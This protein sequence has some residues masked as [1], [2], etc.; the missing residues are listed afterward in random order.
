MIRQPPRSVFAGPVR[1]AHWRPRVEEPNRHYSRST[2]RR[3]VLEACGYLALPGFTGRLWWRCTPRLDLRLSTAAL[4]EGP[5]W[6]RSPARP[7]RKIQKLTSAP[8]SPCRWCAPGASSGP[9]SAVRSA[10]PMKRVRAATTAGATER[11]VLFAELL[12]GVLRQ[13][14]SPQG[15]SGAISAQRLADWWDRDMSSSPGQSLAWSPS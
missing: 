15:S 14:R 6:C 10:A 5:C 9:V 3:R 13:P 11:E 12:R 2:G 8:R 4:A 1:C 7:A